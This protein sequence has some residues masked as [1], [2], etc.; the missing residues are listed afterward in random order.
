MDLLQRGLEDVVARGP[1]DEATVTK[2]GMDVATALDFAHEHEG[3]LVHRDLKP[4]NILFDRHGNAVVTDFGI[5]EAARNYTETT[6]TSVYVGTPTY[7]SPE[8]ARGRTVDGRSDIYS[9][10]ATLYEL[11]TGEKPFEGNDWYE[12]GRKHIE[13]PPTPPRERGARI[14]AEAER[15]IL[16][17]LE[18][19]PDD[20]F[21]NG[22]EIESAMKAIAEGPEPATVGFPTPAE[23]EKGDATSDDGTPAPEDAGAGPEDPGTPEPDADAV[24]VAREAAPEEERGV[25]VALLASLGVFLLLLTAGLAYRYNLAGLQERVPALAAMPLLGPGEVRPVEVRPTYVGGST[26]AAVDGPIQVAFSGVLLPDSILSDH[27]LLLGPGGDTVDAEVSEPAGSGGRTVELTPEE[28]LAFGTEYRVAVGAGLTGAGERPVKPPEQ[29]LTFTTRPDQRPPS[30]AGG[31]TADSAG[32]P[33]PEGPLLLEF[34]EPVSPTSVLSGRALRLQSA[35]GEPVPVEVY[36]ADDGGRTYQV[37]P[38]AGPLD[39]EAEYRLVLG[40][41]RPDS[42]IRDRAGNA[43]VPDTVRF[44]TG[45]PE[46]AAATDRPGPAEDQPTP[47]PEPSYL[48][49]DVD[50]GRYTEVVIDGENRGAPPVSQRV[51]PGVSY[52]VRVYGLTQGQVQKRMLLTER[53]FTIPPGET[54]GGTLDVPAFGT[55]NV[56]G[57]RAGRTVRVDGEQIGETPLLEWPLP[58]GEHELVVEP[59]PDEATDRG[60]YRGSFVVTPYEWGQNLEYELPDR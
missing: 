21:Q 8:Q 20:R 56:S 13:E 18:K 37:W 41:P 33:P 16:K 31:P 14:G 19:D 48:Q 39:Q 60:V 32:R 17:C 38:G 59:A 49:I 43:M 1:A 51:Q 40:H 50:D 7:M 4:D 12:L 36:A 25:S 47:G 54:G 46:A 5:A 23:S 26:E 6:G 2:V 34:D 57:A 24:E 11:A 30:L 9:L 45:E 35:A 58:A 3:G 28:K 27:V 10:G 15:V 44:R 22:A 52:P 42:S 29:P 55:V 53:T